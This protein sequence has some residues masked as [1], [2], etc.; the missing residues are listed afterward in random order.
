M[1]DA[2]SLLDRFLGSSQGATPS[3]W[4]NPN[5][6]QPPAVSQQGAGG[7]AD[8]AR[9]ALQRAGGGG[10]GGSGMGGFA[11]GAAA[12]GILGLLL[13]GKGM[14]RGG[15]LISHGGAAVLGALA[16]R[17]WQ[18]WQ[19]GQAAATAPVATPQ[20]AAAVDPRFL[21]GATPAAGGEPFELALIRAMIGAARADG[22]IDAEER[23]RIFAQVEKAGMDAEAKAF[24]FDALDSPIGVSEVAAAAQTQ[25]QASELYLVSRLAVDPDHPA[26][27]AYLQA[28][29]HRLK[30]PEGLVAHLDRQ[31]DAAPAA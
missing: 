13:G 5:Q 30:L 28:L 23:A 27:R 7:L 22:H 6:T 18:N 8:M 2:K 4:G 26:E 14:R 20:D 25:E 29:A 24:V 3:P 9:Q 16:H 1:I 19:A 11:G 17:A 31:I 21:P 12:G 10:L 15:G